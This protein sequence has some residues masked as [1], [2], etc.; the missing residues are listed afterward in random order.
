[1]QRRYRGGRRF[2]G[3]LLRYAP[4]VA[5]A[6]ATA[7]NIARSAYR[8]LGS[9]V[10]PTPPGA[11]KV[12]RKLFKE[13]V[14]MAA[15]SSGTASGFAAKRRS[16][17]NYVP[18]S[19]KSAGFFRK[20]KRLRRRGPVARVVKTQG[21]TTQETSIKVNLSDSVLIGHTTCPWARQRIELIKALV[22]HMCD[23]LK[24]CIY[25]CE[26]SLTDVRFNVDC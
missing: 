19:S 6:A 3:S 23:R 10:P 25:N 9:Y 14:Q 26:T 8:G 15:S 11:K 21:L 12:A 22:W 16:S 5:T 13:A 20:S 1:M 2:G 24:A 4:H 18:V 17:S 7:A